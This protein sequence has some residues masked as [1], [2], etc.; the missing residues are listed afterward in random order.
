MCQGILSI[1]T[2]VLSHSGYLNFTPFLDF[3]SVLPYL[4][5]Y[6]KPESVPLQWL[7][8]YLS[9]FRCYA[10]PL[11]VFFAGISCALFVLGPVLTPLLLPLPVLVPLPYP[12]Y[13]CACTCVRSLPCARNLACVCAWACAC[14]FACACA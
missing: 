11:L 8:L 4:K 1:I 7:A 10:C 9:L 5:I 6:V 14:A 12:C 13:A 3:V 2:L